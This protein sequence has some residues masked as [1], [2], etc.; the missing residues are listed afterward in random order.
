MRRALILLL[1]A[2]VLTGCAVGG[3]TSPAG[4][5]YTVYYL[6]TGANRSGDAIRASA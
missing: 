4:E 6:D 3:E 5:A 2:A 1:A